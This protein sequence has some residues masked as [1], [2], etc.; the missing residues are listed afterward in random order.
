[1]EKEKVKKN[2]KKVKTK[3]PVPLETT[4]YNIKGKEAGKILLPERVFGLKWNSDL[5]HQVVTSMESSAR[6]NVAHTKNRGDVS[7]GGKKPW[8]QKGTGRAR[9]GSIRSPLLIGGG[10][11]HG[12]TAERSYEKKINKKM[13]LTALLSLISK[14]FKDGKIFIMDGISPETFSKTKEVFS[15]TASL[16]KEFGSVGIVTSSQD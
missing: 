4:I 5:V 7:G 10:V 2:T 14:K 16:R 15:K 6:T 11:T 8:K 13:K 3:T 9:H 1:M 12:P